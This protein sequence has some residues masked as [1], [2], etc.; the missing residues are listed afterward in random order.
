MTTQAP[1]PEMPATTQASTECAAE[2]HVEQTASQSTPV[3][4]Q[5]GSD[6]ACC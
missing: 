6:R 1:V 2:Q 3:E 5:P 4:T